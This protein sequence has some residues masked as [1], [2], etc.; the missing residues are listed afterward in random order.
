MA[1]ISIRFSLFIIWQ[2]P[3]VRRAS[4]RPGL[5]FYVRNKLLWGCF[6]RIHTWCILLAFLLWSLWSLTNL[7]LV[8]SVLWRLVFWCVR[9]RLV[10]WCV[11]TPRFFYYNWI[12]INL[13]WLIFI[14]KLFSAYV[15]RVAYHWFYSIFSGSFLIMACP[16]SF[17]PVDENDQRLI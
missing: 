5:T 13:C 2:N 3:L 14:L 6:G 7:I 8:I 1:S 9:A 12:V 10:F 11:R 16:F 15:N 4:V 17:N